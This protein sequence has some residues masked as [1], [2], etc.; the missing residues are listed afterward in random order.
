MARYVALNR[1]GFFREVY[2]PRTP[3]GRAHRHDLAE[4]SAQNLARTGTGLTHGRNL[5][6]AT[7]Y[8]ER[9][10][11][12]MT[13]RPETVS[14]EL[15][16]LWSSTDSSTPEVPTPPHS[17]TQT[18]MYENSPSRITTAPCSSLLVLGETTWRRQHQRFGLL[19]AD[20]LRHLY[21]LGKTGRARARCSAVSSP[22]TSAAGAASPFSIR[23]VH[24]VSEALLRLDA[25][26]PEPTLVFRPRTGTF[27]ISFNVFRARQGLTPTPALLASNLIAV[28]KKQWSAFWGPRLEHV[29]RNAI[30]AVAARSSAPRCSSCTASSRTKRCGLKVVEKTT[31]PIVREFWTKEWP[32][33]RRAPPGRGRGPGLEQ[34][35]QL[36]VERHGAQHRRARS[37]SRA[38]TC[39]RSWTWRRAPGRPCRRRARGGRQPPAR[40]ALALEPA[41]GGP[42]A[43]AGLTA[44]LHL[45]RRVPALRDRFAWRACSPNPASS[46]SGLIL[47]HQYLGQLPESLRQAVLGNTGSL[48][49]FRLG[50][51]DAAA[52]RSEV[53]PQFEALTCGRC[54]P[55]TSQPGSWL[56][57]PSSPAFS[58]RTIPRASR[59]GAQEMQRRTSHSRDFDLRLA[60]DDVEQFIKTSLRQ[61]EK[62]APGSAAV[63]RSTQAHP[64]PGSVGMSGSRAASAE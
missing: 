53:E 27:P 50:A 57:A 63:G 16:Q 36:P 55:T 25:R 1:A 29:L 37:A 14:A 49:L 58:A 28:F 47:A 43:T 33:L 23:M 64:R 7:S 60:R 38:W 26:A 30:L 46:D 59:P 21:V 62:V 31:D 42:W 18:Y 4:T 52:P 61:D 6:W 11:L 22:R 34:A 5:F 39:A 8:E 32:G 10:G 19:E 51:E 13:L 44:V 12:A 24:L 45:R 20:R 3:A 40:R 17:S 41:S 56:V 48:A 54:R 15:G 2:R 9:P 35:R